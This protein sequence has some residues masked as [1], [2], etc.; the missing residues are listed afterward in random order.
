MP[1]RVARES[2]RSARGH[3]Q[4]EQAEAKLLPPAR[5]LDAE[6]ALN[7]SA[8]G[9]TTIHPG[10]RFTLINSHSSDAVA[11]TFASLPE[12]ATVTNNLVG[13]GIAARITSTWERARPAAFSS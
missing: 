13:S 2:R 11:G 9:T 4:G 1:D 8:V 5:K 12:G 3:R 7:L 10:D 6:V